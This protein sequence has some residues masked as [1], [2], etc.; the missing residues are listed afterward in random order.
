MESDKVSVIVCSRKKNDSEI[1]RQS[2]RD[3]CRLWEDDA[4][5]FLEAI[6]MSSMAEGYTKT[7]ALTK[8]DL[9]V[10]AH[11]D[12]EVLA[13][14]ACWKAMLA[15]LKRDDVGFVGL[16]GATELDDSC[17]WWQPKEGVTHRGA[18]THQNSG[19]AY[20]SSFGPFGRAVVMDG[21]FLATKKS[22]LAKLGSWWPEEG[23][24]FYDIDM[25]LR[26][27]LAGYQNHVVNLP[28][29]HHS[30]G[31]PRTGWNRARGQF[32]HKYLKDLPASV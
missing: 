29:V 5:Q 9:L 19:Q 8:N 27:H 1:L 14:P 3:N 6:G 13:G 7:A 24:D 25:T 4:V 17:C 23:W 26:S 32:L 10:F 2:L 12:L 31:E 21:L 22:V 16:A 18:V 30:I 20:V 28:V 15:I 11:G